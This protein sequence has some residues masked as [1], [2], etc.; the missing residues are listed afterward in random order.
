MSRRFIVIHL[1]VLSLAHGL[2]L[3]VT[4]PSPTIQP[5]LYSV[6]GL[7]AIGYFMSARILRGRGLS[8][9]IYWSYLII[10]LITFGAIWSFGIVAATQFTSWMIH[11]NGGAEA[12]LFYGT[13]GTQFLVYQDALFCWILLLPVSFITLLTHLL[14]RK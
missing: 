10:P 5:F 6:F 8:R 14:L 2:F 3:R 12:S 7:A 13:S 11:I 9:R 4:T 1:F